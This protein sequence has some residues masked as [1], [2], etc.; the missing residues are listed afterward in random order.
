MEE[1]SLHI[2]VYVDSSFANNDDLT[3]QL[4]FVILLADD[5]NNVHF[6]D[7]GSKKS[8]RVVRSIMA[9][10]MYAFV[11]GFDRA[12]IIK[13]DFQ[14]MLGKSIPITMLT[15]SKQVFDSMTKSKPT[16]ERRLMIDLHATKDSYD[17]FEITNVALIRTDQN[18]ADSLTK[19]T[20]SRRLLHVMH[21]GKDNVTV[22][23]WVERKNA[24]S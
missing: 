1:Q 15:D 22:S 3:S 12:F 9:G 16:T 7:F 17:K 4:G 23:Q 20:T 5:E 10:E 18:L 14:E 19:D 6:I 21:S 11:L 24:F 2:R 8:T 13:H